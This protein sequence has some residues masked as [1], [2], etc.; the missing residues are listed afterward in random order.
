[1][2][3]K[4]YIINL[5]RRADKRNHMMSEISKLKN[6][7]HDLNPVYFSAVDGNDPLLSSNHHFTVA[8]WFDPNSGKAMTNGE[9]GCAL[10]HFYIWQDIVKNVQNGKVNRSAID[11]PYGNLSED[12]KV[13][14]LEDDVLFTDNLQKIIKSI[15]A[16]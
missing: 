7:G 3:N 9:I 14:I 12:C 5:A 15:A 13:L 6:L 4:T 1:M 2:F 8:N 10:S 16:K 11:Q